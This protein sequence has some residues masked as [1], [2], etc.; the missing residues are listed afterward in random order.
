MIPN[1]LIQSTEPEWCDV[2]MRNLPRMYQLGEVTGHDDYVFVYATAFFSVKE[3]PQ[4]GCD[5]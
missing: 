2:V 1:S 4:E 5:G 3:E